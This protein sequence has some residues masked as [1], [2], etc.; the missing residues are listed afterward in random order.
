MAGP[1]VID[2]DTAEQM[3]RFFS[4]FDDRWRDRGRHVFRGQP[5]ADFK[6]TPSIC[7]RDKTSFA[8]G[9]A[10]KAFSDSTKGQVSFEIRV[11]TEFLKGC[12]RSG[13]VLPGYTEDL[14]SEIQRERWSLMS[15]HDLWPQKRIR[16]IMAVA[17]HN[18]VPT[19]LLDWT[20]RSYVACYFA[21][22]MA[23]LVID[24]GPP[25][26]IAVWVLD[27]KRENSWET[28]RIIRTPGGTSPN[29]AAQ[30]GLFTTHLV[31]DYN[32]HPYVPEA[33]EF[34]DEIYEDNLEALMKITLPITQ[35][36]DLLDRCK[37]LGIEA[38]TLF[39][40]YEGAARGVKDWAKLAVGLQHTVAWLNENGGDDYDGSDFED[41]A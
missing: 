11:L 10:I 35:V 30:S 24:S 8:Q 25:K 20:E 26:R 13:L 39:P 17:Q 1:T 19:R 6:L 12:D 15:A 41:N 28:V 21:A 18:G 27:T 7:R 5:D 38:S 32:V 37:L 23:D 2:L 9:S 36:P 31:S 16:P 34:V 4:P 22:S 33:L 29:Q 14:M 3:M 40:G